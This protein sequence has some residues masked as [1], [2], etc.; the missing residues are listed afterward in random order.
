[1][2]VRSVAAACTICF[3]HR[4]PLQENLNLKQKLGAAQNEVTRLQQLLDI[5]KDT[6]GQAKEELT[7]L[8]AEHRDLAAQRA[9]ESAVVIAAE[10]LRKQWENVQARGA[11]TMCTQVIASQSADSRT[12]AVRRD[13]NFLCR[14]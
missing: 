5:E 4:M 7:A 3:K 8:K 9:R 14:W 12:H 1:M 11:A 2:H 10:D 13:V 6:H